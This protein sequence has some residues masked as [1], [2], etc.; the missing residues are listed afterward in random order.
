MAANDTFE[1]M[2]SG[3]ALPFDLYGSIVR[4]L[5][6]VVGGR[7]WKVRHTI[8]LVALS[9]ILHFPSF[10]HIRRHLSGA[11]PEA[12]WTAL[13]A[14]RDHPFT[15]QQHAAGSHEE[16]IT[17]RLT[18]PL[19]AKVLHAGPWG[20][21]A[22]QVVLGVLLLYFTLLLAERITQD[23][24][25]A[26]LFTAGIMLIYPG[27]AAFFDT[28]AH[29]DPF[30]YFFLVLALVAQR[31]SVVALALFLAA[32]TDERALIVAPF[33]LLFHAWER[34]AEGGVSCAYAGLLAMIIYGAVRYALAYT[35]HLSMGTDGIGIAVLLNGLDPLSWGIWS[36]L[37]GAWSLVLVFFV[38]LWKLRDR[39]RLLGYGIPLL[40]IIATTGMVTDLTRSMAY[41]FVLLFP[42]LAR[43]KQVLP[44]VQLNVVLLVATVISL[45]HPM[46][47]TFG[48]ALL[49]PVDPL[50]VKVLRW[51][52]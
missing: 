6:A 50:W 47:Y 15:Q 41:G 16:K 29:R 14:Q 17:F 28:W 22:I 33:V 26:L 13:M 27:S 52:A 24:V 48:Y 49:Y 3:S 37:E 30:A 25:S 1:N 39:R 12:T 2:S 8:L 38:C 51:F 23:R 35:M 45:L 44:P 43:C 20:V 4:S 21:Y 10:Q 40:L 34:R 42:A 19:I 7:H 36:G 46:Y 18:V 31:W 9:F 11:V 5:E 32:F